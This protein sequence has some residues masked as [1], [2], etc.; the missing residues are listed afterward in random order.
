MLAFIH[1]QKAA[2]T[3]LK[4]V[5]RS[6]FGLRHLDVEPWHARFTPDPFA[7][8]DLERVLRF[9]PHLQSIHG[10][11]VVAYADLDR[12][13]PDIKYFTFMREPLSQCASWY[14]Y[15]VQKRGQTDLVFE[16]YI[17]TAFPRNRQTTLLAGTD[18]VEV[19]IRVIREQDVYVGLVERFDESLFL[20]KAL[21]ADN[22]NIAYQRRGVAPKDELAKSLLASERTRQMI[23]EATQAD[24]QL[25]EYVKKELYPS[26]RREY[27]DSLHADL[28]QYQASKADWN[29][30]KANLSRIQLYLLYK[31]LL[32][33]YRVVVEK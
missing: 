11:R 31:P 23:V 33:A 14:Q 8:H 18:D 21:V 32:Y 3:T 28:E 5:L 6:S 9:F 30:V 7:A 10:H 19:A 22:L 24:Q 26:Y 4:W 27:G 29:R 15:L 1:I 2:G 17:Q 12:I 25:Y 20:L 16:E 13:R